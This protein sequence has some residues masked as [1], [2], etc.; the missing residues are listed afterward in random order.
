MKDILLYVFLYSKTFIIT[1]ATMMGVYNSMIVHEW[2]M[3]VH[4]CSWL[5]ISI[6][7]NKSLS[8]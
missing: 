8:V 5:P 3:M 4:E 1:P 2:F 7:N 6:M